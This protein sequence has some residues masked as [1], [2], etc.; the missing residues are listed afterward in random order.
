MLITYSDIQVYIDRINEA[1]G[2]F[3][4][5][6]VEY[7]HDTTIFMTLLMYHGD[8]VNLRNGLELSKTSPIMEKEDINLIKITTDKVIGDFHRFIDQI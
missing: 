1:L 5:L 8:L 2:C 3:G 7:S 4:D 6:A